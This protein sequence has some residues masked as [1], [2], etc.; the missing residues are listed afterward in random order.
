MTRGSWIH[1]WESVERLPLCKLRGC[2]YFIRSSLFQGVPVCV[3]AS[4]QDLREKE[5]IA[6][7]ERPSF[8]DVE[9]VSLKYLLFS[10]LDE[11]CRG[12]CKFGDDYRILL[13]LAKG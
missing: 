7:L 5:I 10:D 6:Q 8:R 9:S 11:H 2:L 1:S 4:P 3:T 12:L 13:K